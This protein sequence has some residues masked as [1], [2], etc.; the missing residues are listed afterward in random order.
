MTFDKST[1]DRME[2]GEAVIGSDADLDKCIAANIDTRSARNAKGVG[3]K[4]IYVIWLA[5]FE[6]ATNIGSI[7]PDQNMNAW[8]YIL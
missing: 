7:V 4:D 2:R 3:T 5:R 1:I 8:T 6:R